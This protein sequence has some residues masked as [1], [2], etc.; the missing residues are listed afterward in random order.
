MERQVALMTRLI[1]DLMDVSRINQD[2]LTLQT[3]RLDLAAVAQSALENSRAVFDQRR[4]TV[5]LVLPPHPITV[6]GDATRLAQVVSNLLTNAAKYSAPGS[7]IVLRVERLGDVAAV[8]VRDLGIGIA[9]ADLRRVFELFAQVGGAAHLAQGGLGIGLHLVQRVVEL[10]E[11]SVE[12]RSD[13]L[14]QGSEFIV[15]LPVASAG[16]RAERP[17]DGDVLSP[18]T[19]RRYRWWLAR[20]RSALSVTA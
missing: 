8:A 3:E 4:H 9:P 2:K 18:P 17:A 19:F 11:G 1:D 16:A 15:R 5:T 14:G 20:L 13:G 12:A 7:P 6:D 10:H